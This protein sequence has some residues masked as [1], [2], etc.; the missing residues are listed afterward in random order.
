MD[1]RGRIAKAAGLMSVATFISRIL[2]YIKDMI[3]AVFFGAS[4]LSDTFFAAFRIPN[5]LRE[6][7]AEG[8]MSSAFIPV[9]TEYRQKQGEGEATRLVKITFTFI[10]IVVGCLCILGIMFAPA[11]VSVVAPG[12][13]QSSDKFNMTVMLTRVMFPFLLFISLASLLMGALNT[14]KIFFVPALAPALLNVTVI[15]TVVLFA[16]S[17]TEPI[18][19]VAIGVAVGGFVQFAFQLPAFFRSGYVLG[20]EPEFGHPGLKKMALLLIPAT[21]ALA[22]NQINIIVSNILASYLPDGSITYLYYAM[23]LIQFPIGIFGVAMGMAVLPALSE[24]AV[25]GDLDKLRE[26][27]S[28]SLRLLFFIAV[29]CMAGLIALREPIVNILFQRGQFDYTATRGTADA[30]LFY[31]IGIWSIVG[32]RVTTATFYALQDTK[33]PVRIA[34]IGVVSNLLLSLLLMGTLKHSG[35]ALANSLASIMNFLLLSFF[36]RK[37]LQR[38]DAGKIIKSFLQVIASSCIMGVI[39]WA[40]LRGELWTGSGS[41]AIKAGYLSG[42]ILICIIMYT[43]LNAL[44]KNEELSYVREMLSI[45]FHKRTP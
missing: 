43:V 16:R 15:C 12:F 11:I 2:G 29:P 7:F 9:L 14:K 36:L 1:R 6:L 3:L 18:T 38:I 5:L 20:F 8:S 24:H 10:I 45:K 13:L 31:S 42:S 19:S 25:K 30:L 35:L 4:G 27:F 34:V 28:F 32:V 41:A 17:F 39:G 44:M 23:R 21:M 26:D 22:V 40:L 33:T 37:K